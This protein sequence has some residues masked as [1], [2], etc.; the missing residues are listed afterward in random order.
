MRRIRPEYTQALLLWQ[1]GAPLDRA[2][3]PLIERDQLLVRC[4]YRRGGAMSDE[5]ERDLGLL[6]QQ[7]APR[8][9]DM[10]KAGL[11]VL[12]GTV[13]ITSHKREAGIYTLPAR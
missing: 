3:T 2:I 12:T 1:S 11:L 8:L 7:V 13:R 9:S 4:V 10:E 5:C 6:H